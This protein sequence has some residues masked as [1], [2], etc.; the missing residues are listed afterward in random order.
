MNSGAA[1]AGVEAEADGRPGVVGQFCAPV[2]VDGCVGLPRGD[3]LDS[4]SVEKGTEAD[5][6]R[7]VGRFFELAAVEMGAR[8]FAAMGCVEDDNEAGDGGRGRLGRRW[9]DRGYLAAVEKGKRKDGE[10]RHRDL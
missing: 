1:F 6:E 9:S 2:E 7:E 8:I 10:E 3:D 5:A 4:A